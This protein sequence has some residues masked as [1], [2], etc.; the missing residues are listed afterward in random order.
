MKNNQCCEKC[1]LRQKFSSRIA[2]AYCLCHSDNSKCEEKECLS[3]AINIQV[4][5]K[6]KYSIHKEEC[7]ECG[8]KDE[9]LCQNLCLKCFNSST[10]TEEKV[11]SK[12]EIRNILGEKSHID[13]ER[14]HSHYH[15]WNQDQ[16]PACGQKLENHKQCCLCDTPTPSLEK[17]CEHKMRESNMMPE[18]CRDCG[19]IL[20]KEKVEW[21][22]EN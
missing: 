13:Y 5:S 18:Y 15:C 12:E 16:P 7:K 2:C 10:P 4:G 1:N 20:P 9:P 17:E 11:L 14:N 19:E 22:N 3:C 8:I 21:D 6:N